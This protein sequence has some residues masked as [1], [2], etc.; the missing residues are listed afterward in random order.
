MAMTLGGTNP[1]VNSYNRINSGTQLTMQKIAT[2]SNYPTAATG[3]SEYA[4]TSRLISN[5]RATTQSIQN[6]QNTTAMF[7][8]AEGATSNTIKGLTTL[9]EHLVNSANGSNNALDRQAIQQNINQLVSQ[10]DSNAYVQYNG[11]NL[12]DGS[13]E[14]V[15]LSGIDGYQNFNFGDLRAQ[16]LG[17]TDAQGNVTID[18]TT[19]EA[20]N[21][22]LKVIDKAL[23]TAKSVEGDMSAALDGDYALEASLDEATTQGAQLQ[24]LEYQEA[25][26]TTMEENQLNAAST[27]SDADIAKQITELR[28]QQTME[29]LS[30]HAMQMFNHNQAS[31]MSLL[32]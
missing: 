28:S 20:A 11:K 21:E 16:T 25:L 26:Y 3:A 7:K 5:A 31:I 29:Q 32:P 24:R 27:M 22:A 9:K 23:E 1:Y 14:S 2:A 15:T 4:I 12:L 30:L 6:T 13:H 17:L 18:A 8:T 10:I 19:P